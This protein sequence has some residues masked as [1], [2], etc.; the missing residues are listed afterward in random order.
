MGAC[1]P[2][3]PNRDSMS[4]RILSFQ[5]K[6]VKQR[7]AKAHRQRLR[8]GEAAAMPGYPRGIR[9][10]AK[11]GMRGVDAGSEAAFSSLATSLRRD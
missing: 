8:G 7:G 10:V 5:T 9:I 6:R 11:A 3:I 2:A 4:G 1:H